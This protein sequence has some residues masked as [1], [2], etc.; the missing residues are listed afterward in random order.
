M[1]I[2]PI[3][4]YIQAQKSAQGREHTHITNTISQNSQYSSKQQK[5]TLVHISFTGVPEKNVK[6]GLSVSV[7]DSYIGL[8][9]YK[10]G[11]A[12]SVADQMPTALNNDG[13]DF[14]HAVPLYSYNNPKGQIKVLV[15]P[16]G[17]EYNPR[18]PMPENWFLSYPETM[19]KAKIA[20]QLK[21]TEDQIKFVVQD[22]PA[23]PND[24]IKKLYDL[25]GKKEGI[26]VSAFRELIPTETKGVIQR[27]DENDLS[28]IKSIPYRVYKMVIPLK[29]GTLDDKNVYCIHTPELAKFQ[30]AYTYSPELK[31]HPH[32]NLFTRDFGDAAADMLPKMNT[33]EHRYFNPA[34]VIA[35][36]RTGFP[37]TESII[38]RSV[39]NE[40]Y[41]GYKII[42]I[43][44]NPMPDYQGTVGNPMD[45]LRYKATVDD[46][47]KLS[48]MAEFPDL[49]EIDKHKYTLSKEENALVD[50]IIK[51]FL[52]H[53][54][55]DNGNYNQSI[56][57]LIARKANPTAVSANHVSHTFANEVIQYNDMAR[58]LTSLFREA[59]I[60][61]D[62]IPGR[63]NGC[64]IEFMQINNPKAT[65]G[66]S[67]GLS[68]DM[69]WYT[70]YNPATDTGEQIVAAKRKNTEAFL[71][72]V[73]EATEKRIDKLGDYTNASVDDALNQLL[74]SKDLIEKQ[75][76]VLG[77]LSKFDPKDILLMGW[78]RSDAQKGYPITLKGFLKFLERPTVPKEWKEHFKLALGSG[79][80]PWQM[81]DGGTGDFHLIK[82]IMYKIQNLDGGAYKKN[83]MYGNGFFPNRL[84]TCA[85]YGIFTSRGE[86]QGLSVPESIQSGTPTASLNTGGA[87][88]M[89][90]TA[91]ENAEKANG[92]KT[93]DAFMRNIEDLNW[94]EGTDL[95]KLTGDQI[96]NRRIELAAEQVADMFEDMAKTYYEN[97]KLYEK[98][99][100]NGGRAKFD[101]HN[102]N[103]LNG[104]RSTLQLYTEDGMEISKGWAGRDKNPMKRLV[105]EFGGS[106]EKLK[107][108]A[109]DTIETTVENAQ[110]T[111]KK[112]SGSKWQKMG[113]YIAL[114]TIAVLG[115]SIY[116]YKNKHSS[117]NYQEKKS[118]QFRKVG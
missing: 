106:F 110:E 63:P 73:G 4:P 61:G 12:G 1:R 93:V 32:V 6:Q 85:T 91:G 11:G 112:P 79:P 92:F 59:E 15:L 16:N 62:K 76:Y 14:R 105:G 34:N 27:I 71:N 66:K 115:G 108:T 111:L 78:G 54:V 33:A 56:T 83:C 36:C 8:D 113:A 30:K 31:D 20:E 5:P 49:L 38:N 114:G 10:C 74:Y 26:K 82:D 94:P 101:W 95:T 80:D 103:I 53:Y 17:V 109:I 117:Q 2:T 72:M 64:N 69:S 84:V 90:I 50:R 19:T 51:P 65:M 67:N 23:T 60:E 97:P 68:A 52:Q 75:R 58:G 107:R 89:I 42:D 9:M 99:A 40:Y 116:I 77:G 48:Q 41:R 21:T 70:P 55:D 88:E 96:D 86:P 100:E 44:H 24:N 3:M 29:D 118:N 39:N 47:L 87:G 22:T 35:H 98:M 37:I 102:N 25:T 57:P 81:N 13:L 45:F 18:N 46:Y 28:K 104:G 7:E 43:F